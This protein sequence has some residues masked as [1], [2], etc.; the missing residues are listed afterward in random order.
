PVHHVAARNPER[1]REH[2]SYERE[3]PTGPPPRR[4]LLDATQVGQQIAVE[5]DERGRPAVDQQD[6]A[7]RRRHVASPATGAAGR[8][9]TDP[10]A[11][12]LSHHSV[13]ERSPHS[14]RLWSSRRA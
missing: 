13:N 3:D 12:W 8:W 11:P 10:V 4:P 7:P 9:G 1:E 2:P 5:I 14:W 6:V